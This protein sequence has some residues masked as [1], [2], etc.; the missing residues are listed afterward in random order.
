MEP[1]SPLDSVPKPL[2]RPISDD[3]VIAAFELDVYV[4][5]LPVLSSEELREL[6]YDSWGIC[7][8]LE[9]GILYEDAFVHVN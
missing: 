9:C 3:I 6:A 2:Q 4:Y 1:H 8:I 5:L 7:N